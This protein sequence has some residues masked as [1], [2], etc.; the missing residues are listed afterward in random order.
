MAE[1]WSISER[2]L[3]LPTESYAGRFSIEL[4]PLLKSA[5]APN[6]WHRVEHAWM[7]R[8]SANPS[9]VPVT[10]DECPITLSPMVRPCVASDGFV[11][12]QS[13]IMDILARNM[14]SPM[15]REVLDVRVV[16][17]KGMT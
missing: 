10:S 15:T 3:L 17:K 4:M 13:V 6:V 16:P 7:D 11:Y 14:V 2:A 9:S 8:L 1:K 12:E 5:L